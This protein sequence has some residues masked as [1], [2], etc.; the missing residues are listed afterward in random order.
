MTDNSIL[1][2]RIISN[3]VSLS[4]E[5]DLHMPTPELALF[6]SY[7]YAIVL[8]KPKSNRRTQF[9]ISD[10]KDENLFLCQNLPEVSKLFENTICYISPSIIQKIFYILKDVELTKGQVDNTVAWLY[11][12][13]KQDLEK[14]AF[15]EIRESKQK[16]QGKDLLYTTQFFTDE[17]MVKFMVDACLN[18]APGF[19]IENIVFIDPAL[20]GGNFLSYS[21]C[22]LFKWYNSNSELTASDIANI[23]ILNQ[24]VG[25][26]LDP[27]IIKIAK[28]SLSIN[29]AA[30]AGLIEIPHIR[31]F[32]GIENDS[33]GFMRDTILSDIIEDETFEDVISRLKSSCVKIEY[34]SNP[35]FMGKR[36]MDTNLKEFLMENYPKSKGDLCFSFMEK[37]MRSLRTHDRMSTVSQNGWLNL[38]SMKD[39]RK[40]ILD[41]LFLQYCVD[42]GSNAFAAINGEKANIILSRILLVPNQDNTI[43][44]KLKGLTIQDK[45]EYLRGN[46]N[47]SDIVYLV[48]QRIFR[49]NK[50]FEFTYELANSFESLNEYDAYSKYAVPMQG[51]STGDNRSFVKYAWDP[52]TDSPEWK[53]VSK[54]GGYSKWQGLNIYKVKWGQNGEL[55]IQNPGSAIRNL[56][57]IPMTELVYSDTGT[58]GL[59][60][61]ILMD[62]QVFIASGP[63]IRIKDGNSFC[64]MAFLNSRI[65]TCLLKIMNPKFTISA[66]YISKLPV[67]REMLISEHI[68]TMG[69]SLVELKNSFLATKL[70]NLEY[71]ADDFAAISDLEA[72]IDNAIIRDIENYKSRYELESEINRIVLNLYEFKPSQKKQIEKLIELL[73]KGNALNCSLDCIDEVMTSNLN[74]SCC[75]VSRRLK[76]SIFGSENVLEI[77]SYELNLSVDTLANIMSDNIRELH[78]L[79]NMF[80]KDLLHKLIL[81]VCGITRI[82]PL[83]I[84]CRIS[85][86]NSKLHQNFPY[87]YS[88]LNVTD[89]AISDMVNKVHNKVFYNSP[90]IFVS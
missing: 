59:N 8:I 58:L 83:R 55:I 71:I 78:K 1:R 49:N 19:S 50:A 57:E 37:I 45:K 44:Y 87:L 80:K 72:F 74:Q 64:H 43:F 25:Y 3:L 73:P 48:N 76:N 10:Y 68:A 27:E 4:Q 15:K 20:G 30:C 51:T 77:L 34:L 82:R 89:K 65:A 84:E 39:F 81:S 18:E 29:V 9:N 53:L 67:R 63:G 86:I 14:K 32:G 54:G 5:I 17:Y 13:L 69:K 22:E 79:R 7:F 66:G 2:K 40:N 52:A 90:V 62:D 61:R 28:L 70:P 38:S 60:V 35:P 56:K 88:S 85:E 16:I 6:F 36:D 11:Q 26:D 41:N 33:L 23:I 46:K 47:V 12:A 31:Y 42:M 75:T 24:L 21:F